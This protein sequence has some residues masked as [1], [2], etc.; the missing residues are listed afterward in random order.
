[1]AEKGM[2][3]RK[4]ALA[5][6]TFE[7]EEKPHETHIPLRR[8]S[9]SGTHLRTKYSWRR[10]NLYS[11]VERGTEN[12]ITPILQVINLN[13]VFKNK[14]NFI[15]WCEEEG[16]VLI[17][18]NGKTSTETILECCLRH[19]CKSLLMAGHWHFQEDLFSE[20]SQQQSRCLCL[21]TRK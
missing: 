2:S 5:P 17:Y 6:C 15:V 1:M 20:D 9:F 18:A 13:F 11:Q 21:H 14:T 12:K 10:P 7:K 3:R 19:P 16:A 8:S 4:Q